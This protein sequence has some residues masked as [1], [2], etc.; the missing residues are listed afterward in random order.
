ME[1]STKAVILDEF[2]WFH[3][4]LTASK[5]LPV[6]DGRLLISGLWGFTSCMY[7]VRV[8]W[9]SN[10]E[11]CLTP[12]ASWKTVGVLCRCGCRTI[13][14]QHTL[15][16]LGKD[17]SSGCLQ[18]WEKG[19]LARCP[20]LE[21][22]CALSSTAHVPRTLQCHSTLKVRVFNAYSNSALMTFTPYRTVSYKEALTA[23]A[24]LQRI[25]TFLVALKPNVLIA[26]N[27]QFC[28][29]WALPPAWPTY[30]VGS[31]STAHSH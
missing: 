3:R 19:L 11:M 17:L 28:T 1:K 20:L 15:D 7:F 23:G 16:S 8:P 12:H 9:I 10:W 14:D 22:C 24:L 30:H 13:F 5:S 27:P 4:A 25:V 2:S 6:W 31:I 26:L 21:F 18:E 29:A